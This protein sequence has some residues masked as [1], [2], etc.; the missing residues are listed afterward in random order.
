MGIAIG[1]AAVAAAAQKTVQR[2]TATASQAA[3]NAN[4]W[5]TRCRQA[6]KDLQ[7]TQADCEAEKLRCDGLIREVD[8]LRPLAELGR[9][10]RTAIQNECAKRKNARKAK[11]EQAPAALAA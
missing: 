11:R 3:A 7:K 10:R 8:E 1:G 4:T 9:R 5:M 2:A 6:F